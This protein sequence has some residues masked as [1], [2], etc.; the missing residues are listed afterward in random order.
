MNYYIGGIVL[1]VILFLILTREKVNFLK[2]RAQSKKLTARV[3]EY[4]SERISKADSKKE[5]Y[6]YVFI[7]NDTTILR[8]LKYKSLIIGGKY[9]KK[10]EY[11]P[12]FWNGLDLMYW[13]AYDVGINKYIPGS[14]NFIISKK[15]NI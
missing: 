14:W 1:V 6:P 10:G 8:K 15:R 12:V 4:R 5:S 7:E 2:D 11:V 3:V 13:D 9:L